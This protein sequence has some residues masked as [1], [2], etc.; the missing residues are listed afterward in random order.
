MM[1]DPISIIPLIVLAAQSVLTLTELIKDYRGLDD[2]LQGLI[3]GLEALQEAIQAL[4][5][6]AA[7]D[8]ETLPKLSRLLS[9]CTKRCN[10][11]KR[12]IEQCSAHSNKNR[13]SIRD[14]L[15]YR[16]NVNDISEFR[17]QIE[18]FKTTIL[19]YMNAI[20]M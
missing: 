3:G 9:A 8:E 1:V 7:L 6:P 11:I 4:Q 16:F 18:D 12:I 10:D 20:A 19:I 2:T 17:G 13:Q 15:T 14:W 5:G